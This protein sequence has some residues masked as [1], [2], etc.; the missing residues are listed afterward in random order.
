MSD[1]SLN[2][3]CDDCSSPRECYPHGCQRLCAAT[4]VSEQKRI[5]A[6]AGLFTLILLDNRGS[7]R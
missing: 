2:Q 3:L 4:T 5:D 7:G 6:V 1:L